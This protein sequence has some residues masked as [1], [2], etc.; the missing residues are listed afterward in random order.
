[1]LLRPV[2]PKPKTEDFGW[3][4]ARKY[5]LIGQSSGQIHMIFDAVCEDQA[6]EVLLAYDKVRKDAGYELME[7]EEML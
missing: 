6:K 4:G 1:M 2:F 7:V 3:S 5:A